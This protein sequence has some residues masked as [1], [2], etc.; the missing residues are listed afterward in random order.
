MRVDMQIDIS[1]RWHL[2]VGLGEAGLTDAIT[3]RSSNGEPIISGE[4][5]KGLLRDRAEL[6]LAVNSDLR[7]VLE[8]VFGTAGAKGRWQ[9]RSARP[10]PEWTNPGRDIATHHR[11]DP[12]T[13]VVPVDGLFDM[14]ANPPVVLDTDVEPVE[15]HEPGL[16]EV[17]LLCGAAL[18]LER[19]GKRRTRGYGRCKVSV[20]VDGHDGDVDQLVRNMFG[21]NQ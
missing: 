15:G 1:A 13:G 20:R 21:V 16:D 12:E 4:S 14:E 8:A 10:G 6:L 2:G 18:A 7:P 11:R 9:F 5:L 17:A 19:L 3:L